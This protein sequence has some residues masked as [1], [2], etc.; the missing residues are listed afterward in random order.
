MSA[1]TPPAAARVQRYRRRWWTG[2]RGGAVVVL[3]VLALVAVPFGALL[4]ISADFSGNTWA[5]LLS[6]VLPGSVWTTLLLMAGVGL[7]TASVGV[8]AA[9][10]VTMC[11]FPGRAALEV[12]LVLPLAVP[13]YIAAYCYVEILDFAGPVQRALR[14]VAG[15]RNLRDYWFPEIRSL[16]G[17][18]FVMSAVLFPYVYLT[19]RVLFLTQSARIIDVARTLGC[20]PAWMFWR[21]ALPLARPAVAVGVS[22]ALMETINDIGAVDFFGVRTL[23]FSIYQTWLN[24]SDLAGA[25][26]LSL[27]LL[28][29]VFVLIAMERAAR[30]RQRYGVAGGH[31]LPAFQLAGFR[32]AGAF[33]ACFLP[34]LFGFLLPAWLMAD[35]ASRRLDQFADPAL[36]TALANSVTVAAATAALAV[37]L[38]LILVYAARLSHSR[39]VAGLG[40]LAATGYAVPGTVLAVGILYPLAAL[41]NQI[42][43]ASRAFFGIGTGLIITGSGGAIVYACLVRFL[44]IAHGALEAGI[45][46]V[47]EHFDMAARTLGRTPRQVL[48]EIH[49]PLMRGALAAAALLVFVDTMKELSATIL[50]RPFNFETLAT[51]IFSKAS[52]GYFED[53]AAASLV[54]VATGILPLVLLLGMGP[55]RAGILPGAFKADGLGATK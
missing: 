2:R 17:A 55:A 15:F 38:G 40:R 13:V 42:D 16:P 9:W 26:Q 45:S 51:F 31:P 29:V 37:C 34:V 39:L 12:A 20:S 14:A 1:L 28:V 27:V 33:L 30:G 32:A 49:V 43:A 3:I 25:A 21:V 53:A 46:R 6:T 18:I 35:Y 48:F 23:T 19:V 5:H 24:R 22:L 8:A 47:T 50:L 52:R 36:H 44:A 54:I 11:R 10:L 4:A 41:D 7:G